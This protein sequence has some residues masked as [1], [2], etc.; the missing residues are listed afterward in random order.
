MA[1]LKVATLLQE[2]F[3][4]RFGQLPSRIDNKKQSKAEKQMALDKAEAKRQR[5]RER[6]MRNMTNA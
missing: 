4:G 3:V 2:A 5:K 6:N 1:E